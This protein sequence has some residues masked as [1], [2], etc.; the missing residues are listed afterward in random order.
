MH[1]EVYTKKS[2]TNTQLIELRILHSCDFIEIAATTEQSLLI[3][4]TKSY[5]KSGAKRRILVRRARK[6]TFEYL[7]KLGLVVGTAWQPQLLQPPM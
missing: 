1:C 4:I 7:G 6:A 3:E 2:L 5:W